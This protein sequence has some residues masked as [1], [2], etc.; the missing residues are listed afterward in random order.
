MK[1]ILAESNLYSHPLEEFI[2]VEPT[3]ACEVR[4]LKE[5][6]VGVLHEVWKVNLEEMKKRLCRG[7]QC[8]A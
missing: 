3:L 4:L 1:P 5:T 6:E 7:D 2:R 8:F